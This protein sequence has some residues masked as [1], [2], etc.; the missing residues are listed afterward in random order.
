MREFHID[1]QFLQV[2]E[3]FARRHGRHG[4][5]QFVSTFENCDL[6]LV[7]VYAGIFAGYDVAFH[8]AESSGN[9]NTRWSSS[10]D[11]EA[12]QPAPYFGIL[13]ERCALQTVKHLVAYAD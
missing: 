1:H 12:Q 11:G 3:G 5:E 4:A 8:L 2:V 7:G 6:H 10:D 9:L 13:R